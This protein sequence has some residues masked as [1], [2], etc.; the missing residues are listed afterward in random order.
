MYCC[1]HGLDLDCASNSACAGLNPF[2][3]QVQEHDRKQ[4]RMAKKNPTKYGKKITKDPGIPNLYPFKAQLLER[5][6]S[7]FGG[8]SIGHAQP[9]R[10][11]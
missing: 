11:V 2:C 8:C 5:V 7:V 10:A 1:L 3:A 6:S 4:R 9:S